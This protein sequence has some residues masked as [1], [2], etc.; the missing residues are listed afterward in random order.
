MLQAHIYKG[1]QNSNDSSDVST[2]IPSRD[3]HAI[4]LGLSSEDVSA[5]LGSVRNV[6]SPNVKVSRLLLLSGADPDHRL[7]PDCLGGATLLCVFAHL[8]YADMVQALVEFGANVSASNTKVCFFVT[9][10]EE[11]G[12][13]FSDTLVIWARR[14][15]T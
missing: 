12:N 13:H 1:N 9:M 2:T 11:R 4:W 3:L 8:G 5:S 7:G 6:S 15:H 10:P 14:A